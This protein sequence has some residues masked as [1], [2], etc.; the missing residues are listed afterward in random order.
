M[1]NLHNLTSIITHLKYISTRYNNKGSEIEIFCPYC[2]DANRKANPGHGHCYI[3]TNMPVFNCFR[4]NTSGPILKLLIDTNFQDYDI[5]NYLR[6]ISKY[7]YTSSNFN[8]KNLKNNKIVLFN[9]IL[10]QIEYFKTNYKNDYNVFNNYLNYRLGNFNYSKFYI[11][12]NYIDNNLSVNFMNSDSCLVTGRYINPINKKIR[13]KHFQNIYYF[14]DINKIYTYNNIVLTEGVFDILGMYL[15]NIDFKID[16]TFY[17]GICGKKY[18]STT[19][20]LINNYLLIGKFD[21]HYIFDN[22]NY[23][24]KKDE[25]NK[26]NLIKFGN[27]LVQNINPNINIYGWNPLYSKDTGECSIITKL[28][29]I[30][31]G[32]NY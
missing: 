6:S 1:F 30:K 32:K 15:Y 8:F 16:N 18:I 10:K 28:D 24:S 19:R 9:K 17:I 4:C 3:A 23:F 2:D 13:Y 21:I 20:E 14:Q 29:E 22:D 27:K 31:S 5:I 7:N 11:Y 26:K 25:F 12:P